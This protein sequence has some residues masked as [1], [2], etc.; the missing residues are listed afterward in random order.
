MDFVPESIALARLLEDT[1][2][3]E[4][5]ETGSTLV[6]V[7]RLVVV[8]DFVA[9]PEAFVAG[10][11]FGAAVFLEL[12]VLVAVGLS[13][14]AFDGASVANFGKHPVVSSAW[15]TGFSLAV[16]DLGRPRIFLIGVEDV[17]SVDL[18]RPAG[19]FAAGRSSL[20]EGGAL[21]RL[22]VGEG[23]AKR[24]IAATLACRDGRALVVD[25]FY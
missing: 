5:A 3:G 18:V 17:P 25:I 9:L 4:R 7:F 8:P 21:R 19:F 2:R 16:V 11:G 15:T 22:G 12:F 13:C 14:V 10:L 20:L 6:F 23:S 24:V 1:G